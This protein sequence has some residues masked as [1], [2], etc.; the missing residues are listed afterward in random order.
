MKTRFF[1]FH[2]E[3]KII[4]LLPFVYRRLVVLCS[5]SHRLLWNCSDLCEVFSKEYTD[6]MRMLAFKLSRIYSYKQR[7]DTH[8]QTKQWYNI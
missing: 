8:S 3:T 1:C 2:R 6:Y 4:T 7:N 5:L